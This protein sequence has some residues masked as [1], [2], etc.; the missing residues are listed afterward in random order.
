[1]TF[2]NIDQITKMYTDSWY[3]YSG[4]DFISRH[5]ANVKENNTYQYL[6]THQGEY[7]PG[8]DLEGHYGV[9]HGDELILQFTPFMESTLI[10]NAKDTEMAELLM[11]LWKN[12]IKYGDPSTDETTWEPIRDGNDRK[13]LQLNE[14]A[15]MGDSDEIKDRMNFWDGLMNGVFDD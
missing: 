3:C 12:F 1:M 9:S 10:L 14:S 5:I 6:Y 2:D 4:Y 8:S 7:S 13:Y 15:T 11:S